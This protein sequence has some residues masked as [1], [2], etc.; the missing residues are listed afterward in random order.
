[1]CRAHERVLRC[2]S[3]FGSP[4][5]L[6]SSLVSAIGPGNHAPRR[7][8]C[9]G[10]PT[11][12]PP[13][14]AAERRARAERDGLR[15]LVGVFTHDLSNPLQSLTVLCELALT[16]APVGTEEHDRASQCLEATHRMNALVLGVSK[17]ARNEGPRHIRGIVDHIRRLFGRRF[18]RYDVAFRV[19][20][21]EIDEVVAPAVIDLAILNLTLAAIAR[22]TTERRR[23]GFSLSLRGHRPSPALEPRRCTLELALE[24]DAE[25]G[26]GRQR[27]A[28]S[29]KHR[30]RIRDL[31]AADPAISFESI[32]DLERL[33]FE[34]AEI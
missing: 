1:V 8:Y 13:T 31:I 5:Q 7:R 29:D 15:E 11:T 28:L 24:L 12:D 30:A 27:L 22:F 17:L 10:V 26:G 2:V 16:E 23:P 20:T 4:F 18:D 6:G 32:D 21:D 34:A 19:D 33:S 25:S 14:T 3:L 9:K